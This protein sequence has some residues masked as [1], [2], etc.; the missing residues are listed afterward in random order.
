M[1]V[2]VAENTDADEQSEDKID[3]AREVLPMLSNHCYLCH[4]P[5]QESKEAKLAGLRLDLREEAVGLGMIV[6]GDPDASPVID[7]LVTTK[8]SRRMP[9]LDSV[10]PQLKPEQVATLKQWIAEGALYT[11][12]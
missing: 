1:G 5:D 7:V 9:P 4:G 3:F 2:T 10:K 12:H 6:P 8:A 11:D